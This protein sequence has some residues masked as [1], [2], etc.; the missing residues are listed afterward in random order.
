MADGTE[1][2]QTKRYHFYLRRMAV[3][4]GLDLLSS[5]VVVSDRFNVA[6]C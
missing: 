1:M 5:S 6:L 4:L 2:S 3:C